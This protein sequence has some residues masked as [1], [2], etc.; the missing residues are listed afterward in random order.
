MCARHERGVGVHHQIARPHAARPRGN[1]HRGPNVV[2]ARAR[3]LSERDSRFGGRCTPRLARDGAGQQS[4]LHRDLKSVAGSHHGHAARD[5][6]SERRINRLANECGHDASRS[7][8]VAVTE[9]AGKSDEVVL[10]D[11]RGGARE[12]REQL[13]GDIT[14]RERER[15]AEFE[16]AVD[17]WRSDDQR[18][19]RATIG[20]RR[21]MA[22]AKP[23]LDIPLLHASPSCETLQRATVPACASVSSPLLSNTPMRACGTSQSANANVG[24]SASS[25]SSK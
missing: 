12:S 2:E 16:I 14:S 19:E 7:N 1:L 3:V 10:I 6:R 13:A 17:A 11:R 5:G 24:M 4:R 15:F 8:V 23:P 18:F 21:R 20:V 22:H 25:T 9:S